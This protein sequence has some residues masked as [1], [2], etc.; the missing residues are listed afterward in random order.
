MIRV[1]LAA[2]NPEYR[3]AVASVLEPDGEIELVG[4]AAAVTD[5]VSIVIQFAAE[6]AIVELWLSG[7]GLRAVA[8]QLRAA[9]NACRLLAVVGTITASATRTA[10]QADAPVVM[11]SDA[12][13]ILDAIR[14]A[15]R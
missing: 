13:G 5:A 14:T 8:D 15:V 10:Q 12:R 3:R 4:Q 9:G 6:V 7:G 1:V 2:N 11:Q